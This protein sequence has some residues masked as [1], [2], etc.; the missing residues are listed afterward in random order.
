VTNK[1][2]SISD[3]SRTSSTEKTEID[4]SVI[5]PC[6]NEEP[7]IAE[8]IDKIKKVFKNLNLRGEI[9]V[10]DSSTDNSPL[11]A[12]NLGAKVVYPTEK[13]Y[14]SAYLTGL[15]ESKG[16]YIVMAD[17]DGTYDLQETT[18]FIKILRNN[19]VDLVIGTRFKGKILPRAM[20]GLH[21]YI[22]NPLLTLITNILFGTRISDTNCGMRAITKK[23]WKKI[24]VASTGMEFASEMIIKAAKNKLKII[25]IPITY[26]PR[27]GA[28]SKLNPLKDGYRHLKLLIKSRVTNPFPK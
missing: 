16:K 4:V 19:E 10:S 6:L 23:A 3:S 17:A 15:S 25:E 22:G 1:S 8:C 11:I 21:R 13:G 7:T 12:K 20:P 14:G 27:K 9:I 2:P 24:K 18:K 26:Y 5:I 28:P